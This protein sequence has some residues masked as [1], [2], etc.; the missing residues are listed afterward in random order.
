MRHFLSFLAVIFIALT[1]FY[2]NKT[3]KSKNLDDKK[4]HVYASASFLSKWGPGPELKELFEKQNIFKIEYVESADT[5][6]TVQKINFEGD[7][8]LADV[9]LGMD[10]FDISRTAS[11]IKWKDID[12]AGGVTFVPAIS[13]VS[14]EKNFVPYDWAPMS[15]V[16]RKSLKLPV[17]SLDDLLKP[18]LRGKIA[19]EDPRTSSPGL[20]FLVW[21]FETH[22]ADDA[23]K[24]LRNMIQQAHSYSPS[25]SAAYGLFKNSQA[26][27]V[28]SY[29]TSPIYHQVEE[30]DTQYYSIETTEPLPLQVE[31][32]GIPATCK[33]Y[34]AAEIFVNFL[35]SPEAQKII[36]TKNYMLPVV[37]HVKEAT[38]FDAIKVYKT[39][40]LKFYEQS[41]LEKWINTWT[42]L[43]KND[44]H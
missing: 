24:Y 44:G 15:F 17:A 8:S 42:E 20:Q 38:V 30:K 41:K 10:Q 27:M 13:R 39:L 21:V 40:P 6:M 32:A 37:D 26:D 12:R 5:A 35:L 7:G 9:V 29:V 18:E 31:F 4:I 23:V 1:V 36:M 11:K 25:W 2:Y 14:S 3:D 33:N 28:F 19:L 43:R 22:S 34:E 16:A